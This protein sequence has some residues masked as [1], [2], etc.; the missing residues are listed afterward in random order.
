MQ[1]GFL[2]QKRM[3]YETIDFVCPIMMGNRFECATRGS[4]GGH[5]VLLQF[6]IISSVVNT[7]RISDEVYLQ[8]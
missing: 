8:S 4:T 5:K 7:S 1:M 3:P 2:L 6:T